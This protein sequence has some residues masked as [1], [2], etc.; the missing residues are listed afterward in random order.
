MN[1]TYSGTLTGPGPYTVVHNL[2][3]TN[4]NVIIYKDTHTIRRDVT[5]EF[6]GRNAI[7]LTGTWLDTLNGCRIVVT[8]NLNAR[9][10]LLCELEELASK[11]R[12]TAPSTLLTELEDFIRDNK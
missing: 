10:R 11:Y 1:D 3:S 8:N 12:V 6:L 7:A 9:A 2:D 4:I 5:V